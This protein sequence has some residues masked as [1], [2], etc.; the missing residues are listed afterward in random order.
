MNNAQRSAGSTLS[1]VPICIPIDS[2]I[3]CDIGFSKFSEWTVES[4]SRVQSFMSVDCDG[5]FFAQ[6]A[7]PPILSLSTPSLLVCI[8]TH[9]SLYLQPLSVLDSGSGV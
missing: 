1:N 8:N 6:V 9:L 5:N 2:E 3:L 4:G 7:V